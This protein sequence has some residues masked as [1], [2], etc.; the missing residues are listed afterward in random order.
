MKVFSVRTCL[1]VFCAWLCKSMI[2]LNYSEA[3]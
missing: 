1:S 3:R 2:R